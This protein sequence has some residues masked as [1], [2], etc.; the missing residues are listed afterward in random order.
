MAKNNRKKT[1]DAQIILRLPQ[2]QM[3]ALRTRA[4]TEGVSVS[5]FI[6]TLI[7]R[8]GSNEGNDSSKVVRGHV[9]WATGP[10]HQS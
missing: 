8:F 2:A 9:V 5:E 1:Y 7:T 6:R 4:A 10:H 3:L